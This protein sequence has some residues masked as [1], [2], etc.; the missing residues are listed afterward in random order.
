MYMQNCYGNIRSNFNTVSK[1]SGLIRPCDLIDIQ[2]RL[3]II[4]IL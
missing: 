4:G 1:Y 3:N 2:G